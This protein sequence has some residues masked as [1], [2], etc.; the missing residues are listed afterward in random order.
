M[1]R[2]TF[3]HT[4]STG[5]LYCKKKFIL[6]QSVSLA[7]EHLAFLDGVA[8]GDIDIFSQNGETCRKVRRIVEKRV[9]Q[10]MHRKERKG[11]NWS[12]FNG[13]RRVANQLKNIYGGFPYTL[14]A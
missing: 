3:T 7:E 4:E 14:A 12:R 13:K 9:C 11:G 2:N 1:Y 10:E 8:L 5:Q 6:N